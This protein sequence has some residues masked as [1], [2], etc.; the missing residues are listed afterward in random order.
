MSQK[1][2]RLTPSQYYPPD[3]VYSLGQMLASPDK[4]P[5]FLGRPLAI[6]TDIDIYDHFKEGWDSEKEREYFLKVGIWARFLEWIGISAETGLTVDRN[7]RD[8]FSFQKLEVK[9]M[10]RISQQYLEDS[11]KNPAV[12]DYLTNNPGKTLFLITGVMIAHGAA[13]STVL[14]SNTTVKAK[15]G[16]GGAAVGAPGTVV[17]PEVDAGSKK[18]DGEAYKGLDHMPDSVSS[19]YEALSE[20][21]GLCGSFLTL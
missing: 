17:G 11:M 14:K 19:K 20:I 2:Y 18:T 13:V 7:G 15:I 21:I 12:I 9:F 4:D 16:I 8:L 1:T 5:Q 3:G 10:E 6:G